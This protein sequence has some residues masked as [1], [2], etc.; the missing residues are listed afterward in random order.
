MNLFFGKISLNWSCKRIIVEWTVQYLP[1]NSTGVDIYVVSLNL[2]T[3]SRYTSIQ[4][5]ST[6]PFG[7]YLIN[8][9]KVCPI[10]TCILLDCLEQHSQFSG[11]FVHDW[12]LFCVYACACARPSRLSGL[13]LVSGS[14]QHMPDTALW[15]PAFIPCCFHSPT[16]ARC[17]KIVFSRLCIPPSPPEKVREHLLLHTHTSGS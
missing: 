8:I 17:T 5:L 16:F 3:L 6:V 13:G 9:K 12:A 11:M 15:G 7:N 4:Y 2:N 10:L 14:R 1:A